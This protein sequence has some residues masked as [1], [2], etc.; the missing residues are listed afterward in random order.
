MIAELVTRCTLLEQIYLNRSSAGT[1]NLRRHLTRLY[2]T[3]T[4]YLSEAKRFFAQ[5]SLSMSNPWP[6]SLE[7][8]DQRRTRLEECN[9]WGREICQTFEK[10]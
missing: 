7:E 5:S 8:T 9:S 6:L 1:F 2:E 10:D 4:L 3:I